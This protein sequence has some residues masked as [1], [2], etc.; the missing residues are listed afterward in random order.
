MRQLPSSSTHPVTDRRRFVKG[1][2]A[3]ATLAV[4]GD[5]PGRL[6]AQPDRVRELRGPRFDLDIAP[7]AVN[8]TGRP[9]LATAINGSVPA[10]ILRWRQG[11]RV[12]LRVT[13]RLEETSSIHWH[14]ML[15]PPGMDGVPGLS[16]DGIGPQS[17]VRLRV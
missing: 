3:G 10:P 13:N 2:A 12:T 6:V 9:R 4:F 15:L 17:D 16:F 7:A 5:W 11:E 1:L 14:G 8:Y